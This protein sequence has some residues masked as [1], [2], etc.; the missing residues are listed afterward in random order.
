MM[1]RKP[2]DFD[3]FLHELDSEGFDSEEIPLFDEEDIASLRLFPF[4]LPATPP[5]VKKKP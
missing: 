4:S 1:G 2:K 3:E 5:D